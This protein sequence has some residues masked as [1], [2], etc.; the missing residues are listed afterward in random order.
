[1]GQFFFSGSN[2][3]KLDGKNRFVLPQQMRFGLVENGVLDFTL[4]LGLGG[5]IS[6]YKKSAME[7]IVEKFQTK[8]HI[9][10]YQKFFTF[11]FSTLHP[12]TCDS[13]GR[14]LLPPVLKKTANITSEIVIVGVLNKIEIW[15]KQSYDKQLQAIIE[16]KDDALD[17][18]KMTE[19]AFAILSDNE[20]EELRF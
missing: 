8:Q 4:A 11:F 12:T 9:A 19:E 17:L 16:G 7:K 1:M 18:N 13:I 15:P 6:I 5:C 20:Q 14:V 3:T 10:K 2:H